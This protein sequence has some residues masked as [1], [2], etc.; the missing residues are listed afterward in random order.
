MLSDNKAS[1]DCELP[2]VIIYV[3]SGAPPSPK[4]DAT[5]SGRGALAGFLVICRHIV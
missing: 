5:T 4:P 2:L 3:V 1:H